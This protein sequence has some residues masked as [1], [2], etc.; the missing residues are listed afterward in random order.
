MNA[1]CI[2][3]ENVSCLVAIIL[4]KFLTFTYL[5]KKRTIFESYN[6]CEVNGTRAVAKWGL[7]AAP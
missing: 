4:I 1:L 7:D 6:V 5:K 3:I 2:Q